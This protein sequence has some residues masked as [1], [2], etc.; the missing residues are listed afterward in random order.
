MLATTGRAV[1]PALFKDR[2]FLTGNVFIFIV[3]AVLYAATLAL[4]PPLLQDLLNYPVVT[5]GLVT[6]PRGLGALAAMFIVGRL[7]GGVDIRLI[8]ATGFRMAAVPGK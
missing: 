1:S 6:A 8:I 2:N 3:G 4:L 5:T 7:M